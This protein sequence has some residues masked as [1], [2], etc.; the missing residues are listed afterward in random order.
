MAL[1]M[2]FCFFSFSKVLEFFWLF[3]AKWVFL[4][5]QVVSKLAITLIMGT[6]G[7]LQFLIYF[8]GSLKGLLFFCLGLVIYVLLK[9]YILVSNKCFCFQNCLFTEKVEI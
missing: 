8:T 9:I 2:L 6:C 7:W 4:N 5:S 3:L 1:V